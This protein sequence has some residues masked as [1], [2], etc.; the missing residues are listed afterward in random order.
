MTETTNDIKRTVFEDHYLSLRQKE[1]RL[2][3]DHEVIQLPELSRQH[4]HYTEWQLRK[5]SAKRLLQYLEKKKPLLK[6]LEA[7]CGNGWL[8]HFL[9]SL[10]GSS[11][12][13]TDIN[14]A[15]LQQAS[16][17]FSHIPN[18][19]FVYGGLTAAEVKDC[20][21]DHVIFASSIQYFSS[22][23]DILQYSLSLLKPGGEI[24]ILDTRFYAE[25]EKTGAKKRTD[26]YYRQMGYSEMSTHYFHHGWKELASFQPVVRYKPGVF[27][28]FLFNQRNPFPWISI[29]KS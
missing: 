11:V 16:R 5:E 28:R 14:F 24:Q 21:Y 27:K 6:I 4:P 13:G 18:V 23:A 22:L 12:T 17:V 20:L 29:R 26:S 9:S 19:Q 25:E 7:G 15:E 1:G 8:C 10:P 2:C 3:S